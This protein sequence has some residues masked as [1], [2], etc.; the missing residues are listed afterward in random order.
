MKKKPER[1]AVLRR[2]ISGHTRVKYGWAN[3][4]RVGMAKAPA[5]SLLIFL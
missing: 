5:A 3:S 2:S 1:A 4:F